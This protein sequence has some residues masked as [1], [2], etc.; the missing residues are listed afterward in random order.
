M[1]HLPEN[2]RNVLPNAAQD[3]VGILCHE[4]ETWFEAYRPTVINVVE[5]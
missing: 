5:I 2:S 3:T 4:D 1:N